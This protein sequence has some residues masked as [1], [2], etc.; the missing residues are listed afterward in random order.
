ML[1]DEWTVVTSKDK[2]RVTRRNGRQNAFNGTNNASST[3]SAL[4]KPSLLSNNNPSGGDILCKCIH[5]CMSIILKSDL[6]T[7]LNTS[8]HQCLVTNGNGIRTPVG[9]L[10]AYG[11][12]NFSN[13]AIKYYSA[14]LWQLALAIC[15]QKQVNTIESDVVNFDFFDPVTTES[16]RLFLKE[17]FAVNVLPTNNRGDY[18]VLSTIT[19]FLMPHCPSQLYEN[20]VWSN[21]YN[22]Q[23][24]VFIGNSLRNLAETP[25]PN[26]RLCLQS[27]LPILCESAMTAS[28]PDYKKASE[29][30]NFV[31]AWNDTYIS[32]FN[33]TKHTELSRPYESLNL[34]AIDLELL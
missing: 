33:I 15:L 4:E 1:E 13:T 27:L 8:L 24:I 2:K 26:H 19:I 7:N 23:Q 14:P 10:V 18:N 6:W 32:I 21:Y 9:K 30:G 5:H 20:V 16:E 3:Q 25:S 34:N 17:R 11:I 29:I 12:G 22:L 28:K 31:G